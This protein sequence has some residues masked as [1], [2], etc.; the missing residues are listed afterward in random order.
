MTHYIHEKTCRLF[1]HNIVPTIFRNKDTAGRERERE[2]ERERQR[3]RQRQRETERQRQR[4]TERERQTERDRDRQTDRQKEVDGERRT[5]LARAK[6]FICLYIVLGF[7]E[8][9]SLEN[10]RSVLP[11]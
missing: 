11:N 8:E 2:R 6:Y 5:Q 9:D 4:E 1:A 3:Q 10:L 7:E